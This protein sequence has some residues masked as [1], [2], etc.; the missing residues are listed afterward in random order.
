MFG[1]KKRVKKIEEWMTRMQ[2]RLDGGV[3]SQARMADG[4]AVLW[5]GMV[6]QS[7][8]EE[9]RKR[10]EA[11][12]LDVRVHA[13]E[14]LIWSANP[15]PA[16]YVK[17]LISRVG[18]TVYYGTDPDAANTIISHLENSCPKKKAPVRRKRRTRKPATK[19]VSP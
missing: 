16:K 2:Q 3:M 19:K 9:N 15:I 7:W 8:I 18:E 4:L 11:L 17:I 6:F 14:G 1:L 5:R 12:G 13:Y 10:I